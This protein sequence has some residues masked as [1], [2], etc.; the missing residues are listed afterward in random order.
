[1]NETLNVLVYLYSYHVSLYFLMLL[2]IGPH[3]HMCYTRSAI[4]GTAVSRRYANRRSASY[5][6]EVRY[7]STCTCAHV[8]MCVCMDGLSLSMLYLLNISHWVDHKEMLTKRTYHF[9]VY[10]SHLQ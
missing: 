5:C 8:R 6:I 4:L 1:M 9:L 7:A 10:T 2:W 3:V